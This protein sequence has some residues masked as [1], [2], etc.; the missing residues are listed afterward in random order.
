MTTT[1]FTQHNRR[2]DASTYDV[3]VVG[4]GPVGLF[5]ALKLGRAGHRVIVLEKQQKAYPLPRA[6]VI[7][8]EIARLLAAEGLGETLAEITEPA[9][10][11][12]WRNADGET[13]L[14]FDW[15]GMG[16]SGWPGNSLFSQPQLEAALIEA[17]EDVPTVRVRRGQ[18]VVQLQ[19][20][21]DSVTVVSHGPTVKHSTV[22]TKYLIGCDGANSFV[23]QRL[24][25]PVTDLGFFY[26][27]LILDVI[28]DEQKVWDPNLL[29]V[30]DPQ[31]PVT[32]VPGGPGRRRFEIMRLPHESTEELQS[33]DFGWRALAEWGLTPQNCTIER[34]AVYTFQARWAEEWQRGRLLIAGDAAHQMPPFAGQGMCSGLRDAA[35]L[36]WKLDLVLTGKSG[37]A[38]LETYSSE[39]SAHVQSAIGQ[40]VALGNVICV[41]DPEAVAERD[42]SML[43]AG[44]DPAKALPP[45]PPP[46]LGSGVLQQ[47]EGGTPL[48]GVG[49]HA[50]QP[51]VGDA[52]GRSGLWDDIV[53]PGFALVCV[54]DPHEALGQDQ[55]AFLDAI[56]C[57]VARVVPADAT[58]GSGQVTDVDGTLLP[59]MAELGHVAALVRPDNYIHGTATSGAEL[60]ALVEALRGQLHLTESADAGLRAQA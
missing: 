25:T 34:Q 21:A 60:A 52:T 23:R 49:V 58:P 42:R 18:E 3:A 43:A 10:T 26:D 45:I 1:Q 22:Q 33:E 28:P 40:S 57:H 17:L 31:R 53:G 44:G 19:E 30:C 16:P 20:H 37:K 51:R 2:P 15:S 36:A 54:E 47:G 35:N 46:A 11:Y 56:G 13:L 27:W 38:L 5:L 12:E 7:D 9:M 4:A 59:H 32:A 24:G 29:Q 8:D 48:P 55:L 6:V 14:T 39:R 50:V 41:T